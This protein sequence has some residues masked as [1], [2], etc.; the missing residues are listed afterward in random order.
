[1]I[2]EEAFNLEIPIQLPQ[3]KPPRPRSDATKYYNH[4]TGPRPGGHQ[5][6]QHRNQEADR[7]KVEDQS[8]QRQHPQRRERPLPPKWEPIQHII[9]VINT[10]AGGFSYGG[11][12][13]QSKKCHLQAIWDIDINFV[14]AP[15]QRSLPPIT[16]TDMD[17]KGINLVNQDDPVVVS[18]IIANFMVSRVLIDQG[19]IQR[20]TEISVSY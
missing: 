7:R 2:L 10:I 8:R 15:L 13:N 1:M 16:F 9:G 3:T 11:Q 5:E 17:F 20:C 6:E 19:N 12:S 4:Q 18:I 14:D